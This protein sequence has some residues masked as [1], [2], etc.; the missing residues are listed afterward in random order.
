MNNAGC[1]GGPLPQ[2]RSEVLRLPLTQS[3][4]SAFLSEILLFP[5]VGRSP[6]SLQ[7]YQVVNSWEDRGQ[8][9]SHSQMT[10]KIPTE[11]F[12]EPLLYARAP[13]GFPPQSP[14]WWRALSITIVQG[15]RA[16]FR[17]Q[18]DL[19]RVTPQTSHRDMWAG[20][21][22]PFSPVSLLATWGHP[23]WVI[24][25]VTALRFWHVFQTIQSSL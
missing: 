19:F 2:F 25:D 3:V 11:S 10:F 6:G 4:T 5:A 17:M 15:G 20:T 16:R 18:A 1:A 22:L 14:P 23:L 13:C 8:N 21:G 7:I 24:G 12:I 9:T